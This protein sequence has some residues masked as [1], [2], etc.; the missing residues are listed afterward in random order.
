M[1]NF[2]NI[3]GKTPAEAQ[4]KLEK[5]G[6]RLRMAVKDGKHLIRTMDYDPQRVNVSIAKGKI[7]SIVEVG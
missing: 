2:N 5:A 7:D 1:T 6:H 4:T 3:I